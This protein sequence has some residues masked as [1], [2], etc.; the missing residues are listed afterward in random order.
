MIGR[1]LIVEDNHGTRQWLSQIVTE[2]FP[3]AIVVVASHV[4]Q[5]E[6]LAKEVAFDLAL[7]D[8]SLPDGSGK[9][10]LRLLNIAQPKCLN[11]VVTIHD[12][13]EHI[14]SVLKVGAFGYLLKDQ[15]RPLIAEQLVKITQGEPPLTPS[16]ARRL[17]AHFASISQQPLTRDVSQ[18][19]LTTRETEVLGLLSKGLT[20][21][22]IATLL[23]LSRHTVGDYVKQIYQKLGINT[24]AEAALEAI[25]L[26]IA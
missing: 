11:V 5:A 17:I 1:T 19:N 14:F 9:H 20:L 13:D 21:Q 7:I 12:D 4:A 16:I 15:P 8:L 3:H 2:V 24:R 10:V 22:E 23:L 6:Q 25:K 26:G 18:V